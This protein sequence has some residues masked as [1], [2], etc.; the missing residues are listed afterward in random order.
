M[1]RRRLVA[2]GARPRGL[3]AG[4]RALLGAGMLVGAVAARA[5]TAVVERVISSERTTIAKTETSAAMP[6]VYP[7]RGRPPAC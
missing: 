1:R 4:H 5:A 7:L 2:V 3:L 6:A